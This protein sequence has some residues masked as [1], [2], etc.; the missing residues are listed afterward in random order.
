MVTNTELFP[1]GLLIFGRDNPNHPVKYTS[2]KK[3]YLKRTLTPEKFEQLV[4]F[5]YTHEILPRGLNYD[6]HE[7]ENEVHE[8]GLYEILISFLGDGNK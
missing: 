6:D 1:I 8:E 4:G 2:E 3:T 7:T 5:I